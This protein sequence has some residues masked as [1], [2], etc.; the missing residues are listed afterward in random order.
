MS[1]VGHLLAAVQRGADSRQL[2]LID[3]IVDTLNLRL[4]VV[5]MT[6]RS[7]EWVFYV[8]EHYL[9]RVVARHRSFNDHE[10]LDME[11]QD[12]LTVNN[13]WEGSFSACCVSE[14]AV[15]IH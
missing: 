7:G 12:L 11:V 1:N 6:F 15:E 5:A 10:F 2:E 13:R 3:R 14:R 9:V 4:M 8:G